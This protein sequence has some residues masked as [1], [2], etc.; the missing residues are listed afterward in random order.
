MAA[1]I[2]ITMQA[3]GG[4]TCFHCG[5]AKIAEGEECLEVNDGR[6]IYWVK[7]E[8][9]SEWPPTIQWWESE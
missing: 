9:R 2:K 3:A 8:H 1:V 7:M 5:V 6:R 4:A